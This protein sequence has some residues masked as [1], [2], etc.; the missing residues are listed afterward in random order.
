MVFGHRMGVSVRVCP[1]A[2]KI[3]SA[4]E[5]SV[6][7][8]PGE[9]HRAQFLKVKVEDGSVYRVQVRALLNVH[10]RCHNFRLRVVFILNF[11]F[12]L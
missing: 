4:N 7:V 3:F 9:R 2:L 6:D 5:T 12:P 8:D 1:S 10:F 11:K